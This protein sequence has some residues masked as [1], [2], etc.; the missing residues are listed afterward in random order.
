MSSIG[1]VIIGRN[2]GTRLIQCLDSIVKHN[3]KAVYVDSG[4]TDNSCEIAKGKGIGVVNLD[5]TIPFTAA[6]A[7]NTGVNYL[8]H[9]HGNL[10]Y[11]QFVDGDC[12]IVADWLPKAALALDCNPHLAVVCG[13]RRERA[14]ER[15]LYN[16]F[17]DIEWNTPIGEAKACGGDAMMRLDAFTQVGGFNQSLIAG[18]EPELCVR[19]RAAGH[20]ILRL[21][22]E[23][24][25]HDANMTR[26]GQWW[27]RS[28]RSGYAYTEGSHLHGAPPE[29]HWVKETRSITLWGLILPLIM[30]LGAWPSRGGSFGLLLLYGVMLYRTANYFKQ[31][32]IPARSANLYALSCLVAKFPQAQGQLKFWGDR[33]FK[34]QAQ[35]IEYIQAG[36]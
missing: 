34:R 16:L 11:I 14:P 9:Y 10:D 5:L 29:R 28:L 36:E 20:R 8:R 30:V 32:A 21:D 26:L 22:A 27:K 31:Q 4:S 2:E 18:E 19:L 15:S 23:M 12:E 3:V 35:I 24:T 6:R 25:L 7:R 13:R 17:C 1:I 33:L